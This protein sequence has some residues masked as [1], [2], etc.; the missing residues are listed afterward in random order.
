MKKLLSI[1][2]PLLVLIG[3]SSS[4]TSD[5]NKSMT[6]KTE[7]EE[8]LAAFENCKAKLGGKI[9]N[10]DIPMLDACM[11]EHGF[12]RVEETQKVAPE[13]KTVKKNKKT[14]NVN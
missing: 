11:A 7:K 5:S 3:C 4:N 13:P 9:M 14:L 12:K 1:L 8:F 10:K 6:P 2:L